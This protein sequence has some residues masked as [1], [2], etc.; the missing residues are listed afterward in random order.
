MVALLLWACSCTEPT[1]SS[2]T[3]SPA[4]SPSPGDSTTID[5][6]VERPELTSPAEAID[7]DDAADVVRVQL[8]AAATE[9]GYAYNEQVPGP[10][11]RATLG[12][13]L[14]VE[15]Q[16]DLETPTT[17]HWH[18]V[19]VPWEMDGVTWM[20]SPI[21]AGGSFTYTF[22]LDQVGTFWYHPHF[23][24][25]HQ[26][27][28]GLYGVL[29]VED[30]DAPDMDELVVVFDAPDEVMT[31]EHHHPEGTELGWT[32]NGLVDPIFW[33]DG[34][35][36]V[37]VLNASNTGYLALNAPGKRIAS[38]Q[39]W[40]AHTE[41][42]QVVLGPGDRVELE[43]TTDG[44]L[45]TAPYSLQG[46]PTLGD[47]IRVLTAEGC[48][49]SSEAWPELTDAPTLDP[50]HTDIVYVFQ[51]GPEG[52]LINGE[53]FPEVTIEEVALGDSAIIEVRNLSP[54]HHPFHLHG[55]AFEVLSIDGVAPAARTLEDN[56][57][58]PLYGVARLRLEATNPGDW[59]THCH[60]L[61]H[62]EGGM[63]TVLRVQ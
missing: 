3:D 9:S 46:G 29:I 16:N 59:M 21:P 27:D 2:A 25:A 30:P 4:D 19:H 1:D 61:P 42:E 8:T 5:S 26:M 48:E 44:D 39:G 28:L 38:D 13:T 55:M 43:W 31:D 12:D 56:L 62:A 23:D 11:L 53:S 22:P 57:D 34:P 45:T 6:V 36:R 54:S 50:G 18:G 10:T 63:M 40:V 33:G 17:I 20:G 24:T 37:R 51:G 47:D 60:I 35:T 14:V 32:A 41:P 58:I 7:L 15:F 49:G 52:W